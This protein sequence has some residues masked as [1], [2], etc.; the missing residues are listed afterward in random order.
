M[1][2]KL[3]GVKLIA[4]TFGTDKVKLDE[5]LFEHMATKL[6]GPAKLFFVAIHPNEIIRMVVMARSLKIPILIFGTGSKMMIS[7]EGFDG[8]AIKNRTS[9]ISI[10]G[11]KG[12]VKKTG[13]GVDEAMVEVESGVPIAKLIEFLDNQGLD[14]NQLRNI[15]GTI[16]GNLTLSQVLL[17]LVQKIKV[18]DT[19]NDTMEV[20]KNNLSLRRHIILSAVFKFRTKL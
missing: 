1:D 10:I 15:P 6:G 14:S 5:P 17:D 20:E 13:V 19:D 12:K 4:D 2:S 18:L 8:V 7:D 9:K 16:G 3:S 11:V